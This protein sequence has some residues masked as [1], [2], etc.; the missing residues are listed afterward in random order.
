MDKLGE[1]AGTRGFARFTAFCFTAKNH[2]GTGPHVFL[3]VDAKLLN[4]GTVNS[5]RDQRIDGVA[6]SVLLLLPLGDG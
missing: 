5:R 2:N 4:F 1:C 6:E 3:L